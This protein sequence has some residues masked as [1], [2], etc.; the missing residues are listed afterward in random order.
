MARLRLLDGSVEE[1]PYTVIALEAEPDKLALIV[2]GEGRTLRAASVSCEAGAI[3]FYREHG[4]DPERV[5][6]TARGWIARVEDESE[7]EHE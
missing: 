5:E 7:Y 1:L 6:L 2:D 4:V 3:R